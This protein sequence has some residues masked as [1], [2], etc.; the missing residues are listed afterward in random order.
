MRT[1]ICARDDYPTQAALLEAL[2]RVG[3][4]PDEDFDLE[5]PL[6]TGFLQ[7]RAG[8]EFL[9]VFSDAWVIN[10]EGPDDLVQR[11]LDAMARA[12]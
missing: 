9:T 8:T 2:G 11:V 7:F 1:D 10:L 12:G 3:A 6:P 5:V 4:F